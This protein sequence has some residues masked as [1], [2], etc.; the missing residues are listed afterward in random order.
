MLYLLCRSCAVVVDVSRAASLEAGP[1]TT[2]FDD[3]LLGRGMYGEEVSGE[4]T[5]YLHRHVLLRL[6]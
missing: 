1:A 2:M 4:P 6:I 3:M 5:T